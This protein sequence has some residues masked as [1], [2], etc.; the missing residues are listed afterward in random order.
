MKRFLCIAISVCMLMTGCFKSKSSKSE[1]E[2]EAKTITD[3]F[4]N[5]AFLPQNPKVI[6]AYGSFAECWLLAG[7]ELVGITEDA[8]SE[9]N[10]AFSKDVEIIGTVKE[11]NLEKIVSLSPDYVI[12]SADIANQFALKKNLE[13][14]NIPYGYFS[15]NNFND[16]KRMMRIFCNVTERDDLFYE[17]VT[18]VE[19]KIDGILK[20][21]PSDSSKTYLLMRAYS[22]GIKVKSD[23][24]ADAMLKELGA[25]S[26][27]EKNPSVLDVLSVEEVIANE[28]DYI[29]ISTMG[30][31]LAGVAY[32]ENNVINNPAWGGV[33]AIK[34][35]NYRILPK[36][37]FHYKPNNKWDESYEYLARI[38]YPDIFCDND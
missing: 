36:S 27:T 30:D 17:N 23:N 3:F 32:F 13:N 18:A 37:L 38:L 2:N 12:L 28:P 34:N 11:I 24:I 5:E 33:T 35:G 14:M 20:K 22:H 7:G 25:V 29:F 26:I 10:L 21:I 9:R 16:Y 31:E 8:I 15:V 4:G 19:K 1:C 6:S